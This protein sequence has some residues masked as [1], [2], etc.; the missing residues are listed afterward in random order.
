MTVRNVL[1]ER[2]SPDFNYGFTIRHVAVYPPQNGLDECDGDVIGDGFVSELRLAPIHSAVISRVEPLSYAAEAGLR[3][4]DRIVSLNDAPLSELSYE[5][6]C[7][8]IRTRVVGFIRLLRFIYKW[9]NQHN[10][11]KV[12]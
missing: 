12:A 6:I 3:C 7:E 9:S 5:Q 2:P 10:Y 1:L 8:I 11:H 4:G